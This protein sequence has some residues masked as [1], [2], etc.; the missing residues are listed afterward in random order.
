MD[1][2]ENDRR[3]LR[4]KLNVDRREMLAASLAAGSLPPCA[5]SRRRP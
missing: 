5:P 2:F 1:G 4:A 3:S